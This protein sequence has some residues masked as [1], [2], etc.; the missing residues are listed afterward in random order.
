MRGERNL[1]RVLARSQICVWEAYRVYIGTF[2]SA[3][4]VGR[5]DV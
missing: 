4:D 2:V 1:L 3:V 5:L